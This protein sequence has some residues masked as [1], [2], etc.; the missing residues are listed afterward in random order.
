L[1]KAHLILAES[2]LELI[3]PEIWHHPAIHNY[4]R[5]RGKRPSELVLDI[6]MHY[7]AMKKL[8]DFLKRGRPDIVHYC[9]LLA[10]DSPLNK[11]NLL[12]TIVHTYQ[13]K[14]IYIDPSTRIPRNYN[15]FIGLIEQLLVLGKVPPK[16][17]KPLLWVKS[18]SL[19]ELIREISPSKVFLL[20]E[21]GVK[22]N[23]L[24]LGKRMAREARPAI[25]VGGFQKGELRSETKSL[26]DE[27]VCVY[28]QPLTSWSVLAIVLTALGIAIR[29]V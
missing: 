24:T 14:T 8:P 26:A 21:G 3:P 15:R 13:D 1:E 22:Y 4:A 28:S 16:S 6:S 25:I 23:A 19:E 29:I 9:L 27:I 2:A 5:K 11:E 17:E 20:D 12:C 10:L 7:P 18:K